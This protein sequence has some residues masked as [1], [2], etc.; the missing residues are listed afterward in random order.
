[1]SIKE[2]EPKTISFQSYLEEKHK[3][4]LIQKESSRQLI[5]DT[6]LTR[7]ER[8]V[9][10]LY[11]YEEMTIKEIAEELDLSEARVSQ[12][13]SSIIARLKSDM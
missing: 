4:A 7:A 13:H 5:R 8:L 6:Q 3:Q 11:Y 9:L 10:V 12:M 2:S 1:M